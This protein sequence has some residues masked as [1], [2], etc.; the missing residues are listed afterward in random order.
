MDQKSADSSFYCS[1]PVLI[2]LTHVEPGSIHMQWSPSLV[3]IRLESTS[4]LNKAQLQPTLEA[5]SW[6]NLS[7]TLLLWEEES[8]QMV[9][10]RPLFKL[11]IW[12][13]LNYF[14]VC[15]LD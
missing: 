8:F 15:N 1:N 4:T 2:A 13:V 7:S 14:S 10:T 12:K 11:L 9:S 5:K 3:I 6:A